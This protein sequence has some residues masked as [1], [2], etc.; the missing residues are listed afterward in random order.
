MSWITIDLASARRTLQ[1]FTPR[2]V[3]LVS[4]IPDLDTPMAG[5]DWALGKAAA[6]LVLGAVDYTEHAKGVEQCYQMDPT[7]MAGSQR[8]NLTAMVERYGP[9][10]GTEL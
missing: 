7:G 8:R 4:S 2:T 5:S 3:A 1:E 6:H 10:L 9:T